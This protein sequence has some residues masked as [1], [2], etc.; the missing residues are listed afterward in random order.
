LNRKSEEKE[1]K[2]PTIFISWGQ[3]P[4]G[5]EDK[6]FEIFTKAHEFLK[7]KKQEGKIVG[8]EP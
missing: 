5:R 1:M 3:V 4:R 8:C 6:A 2:E 7:K